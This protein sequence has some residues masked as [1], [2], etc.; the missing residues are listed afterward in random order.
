[1]VLHGADD[2]AE[3]AVLRVAGSC[4]LL[5]PRGAMIDADS[6]ASLLQQARRC[7][8]CASADR[9]PLSA[10]RDASARPIIPNSCQRRTKPGASPSTHVPHLPL[11]SAARWFPA[12]PH[13]AALGSTNSHG[14]SDEHVAGLLMP[15]VATRHQHRPV[16]QRTPLWPRPVL[17]RLGCQRRNNGLERSTW[18]QRI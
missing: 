3:R 13:L 5:E 18:L 2:G 8:A 11:S 4:A 15:T 17:P 10:P 16:H 12:T 1:V 14:T 7:S 6:S 9:R